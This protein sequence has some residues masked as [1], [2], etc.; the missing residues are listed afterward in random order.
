[1]VENRLS[2]TFTQHESER[3]PLWA[4][5]EKSGMHWIAEPTNQTLALGQRCEKQNASS[6]AHASRL[7]QT[8]TD[9]KVAMELW[10]ELSS[11]DSTHELH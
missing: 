2:A 7:S 4:T 6:I 3:K 8:P 10:E 9:S 5:K 11:R 1:M